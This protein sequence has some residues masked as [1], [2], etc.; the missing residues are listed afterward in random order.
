MILKQ[1]QQALDNN[2]ELSINKS[3]G[4]IIGGMSSGANIATVLAHRSL[5][6]PEL[7]GII[8]GQL[9]SL[10]VVISPQAYPQAERYVF[11]IGAVY[12]I[13]TTHRVVCVTGS[14]PIFF[15]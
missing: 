15:Q 13:G 11:L 6:N 7:K 10:P 8:S 5:K 1:T 14:N 12:F 3:K 9:L 2:A 4:V